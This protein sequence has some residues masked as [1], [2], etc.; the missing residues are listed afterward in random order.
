MYLH[1]TPQRN[2]DDSQS[3]IAFYRRTGHN[4]DERL[5]PDQLSLQEREPREVADG[6]GVFQPWS[7]RIRHGARNTT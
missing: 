2:I 6:D 3:S 1:D 4:S 7:R 5:Q